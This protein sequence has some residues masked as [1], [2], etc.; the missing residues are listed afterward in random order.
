VLA[1]RNRDPYFPSCPTPQANI[2]K[3]NIEPD[4]DLDDDEVEDE[5]RCRRSR[6]TRPQGAVAASGRFQR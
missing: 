2:E 3:A 5:L 4:T 1:L 6:T